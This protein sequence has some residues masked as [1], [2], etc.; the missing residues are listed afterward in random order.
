MVESTREAITDIDHDDVTKA[1]C[2]LTR[3]TMMAVQKVTR[4]NNAGILGSRW[5]PLFTLLGHACYNHQ[6]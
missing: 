5:G 1:N 4:R 2:S 6:I 3:N